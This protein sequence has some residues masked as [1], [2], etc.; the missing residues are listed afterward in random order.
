MSIGDSLAESIERAILEFPGTAGQQLLE[1][2][3]PVAIATMAVFAAIY[4]VAHVALVG[5]AADIVAAGLLLITLKMA[6]DEVAAIVQEIADFGSI[7]S[8]AK[9]KSDLDNACR[10]PVSA[11][12]TLG[13]E[14]V[15]A[16]L[17]PKAGKAANPIWS[18]LDRRTPSRVR[19]R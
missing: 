7:A 17:L 15:V 5:F 8:S 16:I 10:S 13:V 12:S 1:L 2:L 3:A 6:G 19:Y 9:T 11:F 4:I 18:P 14:V